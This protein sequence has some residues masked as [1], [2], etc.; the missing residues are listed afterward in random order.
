MKMTEHSVYYF[1]TFAKA[2]S[3]NN[4]DLLEG[5]TWT[6]SPTIHIPRYRKIFADVGSQWRWTSRTLW[7]DE[8][9]YQR[10]NDSKCHL[11]YLTQADRDIGFVE[12]YGESDI[13]ISFMG[14]IAS[15]TGKGLGKALMAKTQSFVFETLKAKRLWLHTCEFD[16]P[17]ARSFYE[18][19][20]FVQYDQKYE[21]EYIAN[22][23]EAHAP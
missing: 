16:H 23:G 13:E 22:I 9:L 6:R 12:L 21:K 15:T 18:S 20:G 14:L 3:L 4:C 2:S 5:V 8:Q 7:S 19:C 10:L 1:E 11:F 17:N